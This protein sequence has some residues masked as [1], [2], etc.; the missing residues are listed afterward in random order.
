MIT[1]VVPPGKTGLHH[2]ALYCDDFDADYAF[3]RNAGVEP[4]FEG[5]TMGHRV[6][7]LDTVSQLG[8]LVEL[9]TANPVTDSVFAQFR[10][11]AETWDGT[12]PIRTIG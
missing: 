10:A 11:A 4:I 2:M 6:C 8:F 1:E 12:D 3:Y 9:I 7:W 5:L